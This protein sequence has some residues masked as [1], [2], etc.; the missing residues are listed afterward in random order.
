VEYENRRYNRNELDA[1]GLV[2]GLAALYT[3]PSVTHMRVI[4]N[5]VNVPVLEV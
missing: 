2:M 4:V 3:P 5:K 1:L